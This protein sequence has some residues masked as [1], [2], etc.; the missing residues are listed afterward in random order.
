MLSAVFVAVLARVTCAL[1]MEPSW[2]GG[3][4]WGG[5]GSE[6]ATC[7]PL[8]VEPSRQGGWGWGQRLV[9]CAPLEMESC[10]QGGVWGGGVR[11]VGGMRGAHMAGGG[12]G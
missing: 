3:W 11:W 2:Q 6:V 9:T 5:G 12:A 8:G 10:W 7:A 4:V 1:E